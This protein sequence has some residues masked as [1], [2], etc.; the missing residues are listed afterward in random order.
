MISQIPPNTAQHITPISKALSSLSPFSSIVASLDESI[1]NELG[2]SREFWF[3][4]LI[5]STVLVF[6]GVVLEEPKGGYHI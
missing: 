6:I 2:A 3:V 4:L 5:A 1:K